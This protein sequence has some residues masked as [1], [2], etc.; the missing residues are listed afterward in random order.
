MLVEFCGRNYPV[1]T[2]MLSS[3]VFTELP[4][5]KTVIEK[6]PSCKKR[7]RNTRTRNGGE[8]QTAL[9]F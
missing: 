5:G 4:G 1:I 3:K 8:P 6:R 2:L 7:K 9:K